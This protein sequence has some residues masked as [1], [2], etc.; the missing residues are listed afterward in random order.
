[1]LTTL[2]VV[3][4]ADDPLRTLSD[5]VGQ[6]IAAAMAD[7]QPAEVVRLKSGKSAKA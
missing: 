7:R 3:N 1:L 4:R 5:Q 2:L 6:R